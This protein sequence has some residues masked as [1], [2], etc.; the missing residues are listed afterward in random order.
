MDGLTPE[1]DIKILVVDDTRANVNVLS[2]TL[3]G[4]GYEI[5]VALSGEMALKILKKVNPD[6][7]LLDVMMPGI[8]GFDVCRE[9]KSD[10]ETKDIPII[11]LTAKTDKEDI[12][13]GFKL[14]AIDF[15]TKPFQQEELLAR[16]ET[17]VQLRKA[18]REKEILSQ[19]IAESEKIYRTI[20]EKVPELIF[21]LDENRK[22]IFANQ[23][24][25]LMGYAP[26]ELIGKLVDELIES[27]NKEDVID[28]LATSYVGPLATSDLEVI[29]KI[30]PDSTIFEHMQSR[31]FSVYAV[32]MWDVPDEEAFK[33]NVNKNFLGTLCIATLVI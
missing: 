28:E 7:I 21:K 1:E 27:D 5:F 14:G 13:K 19:K 2:E 25:N 26:D 12:V 30:N 10:D 24:F 20:I 33:N 16:V 8:D 22:I 3:G 9:I 23:A 17:Q 18:Q 29:F 31:K 32:G 15:V 4:Q 6:L 11:F